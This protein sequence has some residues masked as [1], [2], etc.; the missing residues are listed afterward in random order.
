MS[1]NFIPGD[2]TGV[3][4]VPE[5]ETFILASASP[6]RAELLKQI[7]NKFDIIPSNI[8]ENCLNGEGSFDYVKRISKEKAEA[9]LKENQRLNS[10]PCWILAADTE[11]VLGQTILG[12]PADDEQV[13]WM[14]AQLQDRQHEV[15]TGI[16]LIHKQRGICVIEAVGTRV[17]M[18]KIQEIEMDDYIQSGEPFDKAG[19]YAIQG[20]GGQFVTKFEGSY[21]NVIGLP[22][23][24]IRELFSRHGFL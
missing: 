23:E 22:V 2:R 18:R 14:L 16:C 4:E 24:R 10:S 11:V 12:K 6:R 20:L 7:I 3:T 5:G 13:R 1:A 17:W 9:V 19:G 8:D 21:T 15:I